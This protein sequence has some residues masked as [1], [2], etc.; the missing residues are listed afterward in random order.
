TLRI[1]CDKK[2][3]INSSLPRTFAEWEEFVKFI[4]KNHKIYYFIFEVIEPT[5]FKVITFLL[6]VKWWFLHRY[7]KKYKYNVIYLDHLKPEYYDY[8]TRI[9]E[10]VYVILKSYLK[11]KEITTLSSCNNT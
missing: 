10:A 5:L 2:F 7:I 9:E 11:E 6:N 8:D 1:F 4:R 3:G